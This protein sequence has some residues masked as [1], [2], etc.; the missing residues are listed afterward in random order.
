MIALLWERKRTV[1]LWAV[2]IVL[3]T[4]APLLGV[5][6]V[7][8]AMLLFVLTSFRLATGDLYVLLFAL[9]P[10][11]NI[12]KVSEGVTSLYTVAEFFVFA[13]VMLRLKKTNKGFLF[14]IV[15]LLIY[16][17]LMP[18]GSGHLLLVLKTVMGLGLFYGFCQ[19]VSRRD[20]VTVGYL[21]STT[22]ILMMLLCLYEPYR[23]L[24]EK[25]LFKVDM[26]RDTGVEVLRYGG[27]LGDANF[28]SLLIIS[29][30]T[31]LCVLYYHKQIGWEF[32]AFFVVL[33][34]LGLFTYSK[35]YILCFAMLC[36]LLVLLVLYPK[37]KRLALLSALALGALVL[38]VLSGRIE[39]FN[40]I[41]RRFMTTDL[42][43]GRMAINY[44]YLSYIFS[45]ARRFLL[46]SSISATVIEGNDHIV[47]NTY[48]E[49][50]Y[51]LGAAGGALYVACLMAGMRRRTLLYEKTT[52]HA[53]NFLPLAFVAVM[54]FFLP[55]LTDYA[56]VF[57][58]MIAY[59]GIH[60]H[61]LPSGD[62]QRGEA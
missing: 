20:M 19:T 54:L 18:A 41:F 5:L 13:L 17:L 21:L 42:T 52:W 32:W 7:L 53:V 23:L 51:R 22:T 34:G 11:A 43:T 28:C 26:Y 48:I 58:L 30:L 24:I 47:H 60:I 4:V 59:A 9:L 25:Y 46:G 45:D 6:P 3:L 56:L 49:L 1:A 40:V 50:I 61:T 14:A 8:A 36:V 57:H 33:G 55:A 16:M 10:Y 2:M 15:T 39:V 29:V 35:S 38:I 62:K 27:F 44:E 31:L 12:F 37:N